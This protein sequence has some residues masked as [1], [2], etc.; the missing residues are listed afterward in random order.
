VRQWTPG[1]TVEYTRT[2]FVPTFPHTGETHVEVGLYAPASGDRLPLAGDDRGLRAYRVASFNMSPQSENL[3][4]IFKDGWH[5]TEVGSDGDL[6]W[7]WSTREGTIAFRN[8]R[9]DAELYLQVDQA[10]D[11]FAEPQQVEVRLGS[12]VLDSFSLPSGVR[13]LRR[14][15]LPAGAAGDAETVELTIAVDKTF[16][17]SDVPA[18]GSSD[19]RELGIRVFRAYLEPK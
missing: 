2:M 11:A 4:V 14:F 13:T 17:P 19:D 8:P 5:P 12:T 6:E 10:V 18:L 15:T 1:A 16:V 9:Q 7:Q 3:F